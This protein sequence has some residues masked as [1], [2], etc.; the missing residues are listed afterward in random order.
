MKEKEMIDLLQERL[1]DNYVSTNVEDMKIPVVTDELCV[2][3]KK[4]V[5]VC[6]VNDE[7]KAMFALWRFVTNEFPCLFISTKEIPF[8]PVS[9]FV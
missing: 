5:I 4:R 2:V 7:A 3:L 8:L 6:H 9:K 1:S